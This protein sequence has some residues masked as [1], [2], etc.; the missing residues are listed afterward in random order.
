MLH[1]H[2]AMLLRI[3]IVYFFLAAL[4][5]RLTRYDGGIALLWF[6]TSYLIAEMSQ[7]RRR[8]WPAQIAA[9]AV[10]NVLAT[11]LFGLGWVAAVPLTAA[12]MLEAW[13]AS[14]LLRQ[15]ARQV[16]LESLRWFGQFTI[17]VVLIAPLASAPLAAFAGVLVGR[18]P[19]TTFLHFFTGHALSNLTFVPVALLIVTGEIQQSLRRF[20]TRRAEAV[21]LMIL[22]IATTTVSF[23]QQFAPL[24][25]L[26]ILPIILLAFRLGRGAAAASILFLALMGGAST[27]AGHGPIQTLAGNEGLKAQFFQFYL[28]MT[29]LTVWPVAADLRN[30]ARLHRRLRM[31]ESRYRLIA[32]HSS[33]ILMQLGRNGIIQ[34]VS[35]S[36]LQLGGYDPA[37]LVGR[38]SAEI[39]APEDRDEILSWHKRTMAEPGRTFTFEYRAMT[40][41]G[42]Q[43]WFETHAQALVNVDGAV[44]GTISIIRDIAERKAKEQS[45]TTAALTD[46]LTGLPNRRAFGQI[47]AAQKPGSSPSGD[48]LALIDIDHFKRVNDRWGHEVGDRVL[49]RFAEIVR[50]VLRQSDHVAR[51]GGEEFAILFPATSVPEAMAICERLRDRFSTSELEVDGSQVRVTLSG[52]VAAIGAGGLDPALKAADAALYRAKK[53]GRDQLASVDRPIRPD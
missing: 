48:T 19:D 37:L 44:I 40:A 1:T 6:G 34:Y 27:L 43:R 7:V 25:F 28:A 49:Q 10:G 47:V 52:G 8:S 35:P 5:I 17:A 32:D 31:S 13:T 45:L 20:R 15:R 38:L 23:N 2:W 16:P 46:S 33:D 53:A 14:Y 36:I 51:M 18:P 50:N 9:A 12:N 42:G 3:G 41:D 11:G 29:V 39:I 26:P 4:A 21:G 30:R 24:L 22:S